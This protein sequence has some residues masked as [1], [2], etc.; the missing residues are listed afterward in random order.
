MS[1]R[2][3]L[4]FES[5][6]E[7]AT[8]IA[9]RDGLQNLTLGHIASELGVKPPSL[10]EHIDGLEGLHRAL[11]LRGFQTMGELLTKATVGKSRDD[12]IRALAVEMRA[13]AREKPA[14]YESTVQTAVGDSKEIQAA[15]DRVLETLNAVL[16][17]YGIIGKEAIHA[18]RYLR[19][20]LHGFVS[21]EK[22]KG[23]GLPVALDESFKRIVGVL[24]LDLNSW[25]KKHSTT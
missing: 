20:L 19:S 24:V 1:P 14:L 9:D 7:T 22:S 12:A 3:G 5:V 13:F 15:A 2:A 6:V 21:L 11:R 18:A 17:G 23:F 25:K 8:R 10:Y 16:A 4:S